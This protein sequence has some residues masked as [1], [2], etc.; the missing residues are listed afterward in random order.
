MGISSTHKRLSK[1]YSRNS[2]VFRSFRSYWLSMSYWRKVAE[3][4]RPSQALKATRKHQKTRGTEYRTAAHA[5]LLLGE[6]YCSS[7][8]WSRECCCSTCSTPR[9]AYMHFL[10][11]TTTGIANQELNQKARNSFLDANASSSLVL[12]RQLNVTL[13]FNKELLKLRVGILKRR[14]EDT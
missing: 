7:D 10:L 13:Y 12:V 2:A 14:R 6:L 8:G 4:R 9:R 5:A 11:G 3:L 1:Y